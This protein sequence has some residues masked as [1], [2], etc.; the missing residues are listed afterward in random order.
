[1]YMAPGRPWLAKERLMDFL[2]QQQ[3]SSQQL[4][5]TMSRVLA[6]AGWK[7][8]KVV[9]GWLDAAALQQRRGKK[10]VVIPILPPL[11]GLP[12]HQECS[13]VPLADETGKAFDY[14]CTEEGKQEAC[15]AFVALLCQQPSV[16]VLHAKILALPEDGQKT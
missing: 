16:S 14:Q 10:P 3:Q 4:R 11:L 12:Y 1:M 13:D 15:A 5:L 2:K 9:A 6:D 7:L 8:E